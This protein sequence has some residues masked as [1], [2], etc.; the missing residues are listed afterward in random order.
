MTK[1]V[2]AKSRGVATSLA[3]LAA[4]PS[5]IIGR[6]LAAERA[7][8][9]PGNEVIESAYLAQNALAALAQRVHEHRVRHFLIH[10]WP[11]TDFA[12]TSGAYSGTSGTVAAQSY[13][14]LLTSV[15]GAVENNGASTP[16]P[17]GPGLGG[18]DDIAC[19]FSDFNDP[20]CAGT[21]DI[22]GRVPQ[23]FTPDLPEPLATATQASAD[24]QANEPILPG[25]GSFAPIG[26]GGGGGTAAVNG[27]TDG[28]GGGSS[29]PTGSEDGTLSP[30][31][32]PLPGALG[33]ALAGFG[34]L[35]LFRRRKPS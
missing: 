8:Q 24:G 23:S 16:Q 28:L 20:E 25:G 29:E 31:A 15:P 4:F 35:A 27:P 33:F 26:G 14:V 2:R 9:K 1:Y 11:G 32:V 5:V 12:A 34:A 22:F 18:F 3:E 17:G 30:T 10:D 19:D 21:E 13:N 6:I 7:A